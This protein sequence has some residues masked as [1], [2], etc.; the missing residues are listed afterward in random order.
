MK[1]LIAIFIIFPM[2]ASAQS[3]NDL[4]NLWLQQH[5]VTATDYQTCDPAPTGVIGTDG[6]CSWGGDLGPQPT[7]SQL[8]ALIPI[9]QSQQN[10]AI[11]AA[12]ALTQYN[13]NIAQGL[14]ISC[15]STATTCT[16]A[17]T[18]TYTVATAFNSPSPENSTAQANI[19]SIETAIAAGRGLPGGGT[20]FIYFDKSGSPHT[21]NSDSW[22]EFATAM[23]NYSYSLQV[24]LITAKSGG[25]P[26]WPVNTI[27]LQ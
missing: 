9:F 11:S 6:I 8:Q 4:V 16:S 15:T 2:I 1:K 5:S 24:A 27:Q 26:T 19:N 7:P 10:L 21:F 18:G 3:A 20:S 23:F 13:N 17:I 12:S 14:I 25:T 22:A